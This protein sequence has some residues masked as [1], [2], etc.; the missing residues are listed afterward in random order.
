MMTAAG[1]IAMTA[2]G[3]AFAGA[4]Y[5]AASYTVTKTLMDIALDHE[6]PKI[7]KSL[8]SMISRSKKTNAFTEARNAGEKEITEKE[9]EIVRILAADGIELT[10]HWFPASRPKRVIIAFHGWRARWGRDFGMIAGFW[11]QEEASMLL[12][13]QRGQNGSRCKHMG[14][15]LTERFDCVDWA[16]WA[17]EKSPGIPIYLAGISM[18]G[19]TVLMAADLDLPKQVC[20]IM[21]DCA[22]TSPDGIWEHVVHDNLHLPYKLRSKVADLICRSKIGYS[23]KEFSTVD[24]LKR[25]K[26]PVLLIHG[27]DDNFVPVSMCYD[28]YRACATPVKLLVVPGAD[29][30]MSYYISRDLYEKTM[31]DFWAESEQTGRQS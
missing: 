29:H 30:G 28:N 18:G 24:S 27:A 22:F 13:E 21:A 1:I 14:F 9:H 19:S 23:S 25:A 31:S 5:S 16:K 4:A 3:C 17:A 8:K 20:G 12:V 6:P 26:V 11:E 15:G 2:G 7:L 10:G